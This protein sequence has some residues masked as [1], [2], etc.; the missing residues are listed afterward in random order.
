MIEIVTDC[1]QIKRLY[2]KFQEVIT[3]HFNDKINC[4]LGY[5]GG[6]SKVEVHYS[7]KLN[8][9]VSFSIKPEPENRYWC[10]FG[11]NK[12]SSGKSNSIV[13]EINFSHNSNNKRI[14]GVF[15]QENN[16][17]MVLH[18]GKIGGGKKGIGKNLLFDKYIGDFENVIEQGKETKFCYI[19]E[20]NSKYFPEQLKLFVT[21]INRIKN[22]TINPPIVAN[23]GDLT[24][25][26]YT[27][28]S[29]GISISKPKYPIKRERIHGIVV[30]LLR[31]EI[32]KISP[33]VN[34]ANDKERDLFTYNKQNTILFEV[35]TDSSK[36]S[37]YSAIGQLLL[38]S[39]PMKKVKLVTVLP[40]RLS[41]D[42]TKKINE[43]GIEILYYRWEKENSIVFD[44]LN[45]ILDL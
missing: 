18:R 1:P 5:Q 2:K 42:V 8:I 9:W 36:Q 37:L 21:E 10:G 6:S 30:D 13:V 31:K 11:I 26:Q 19:G 41:K 45:T 23:F 15:A 33:N 43:L 27:A 22:D 14:Q 25:F 40:D 20:L 16:N 44:N 17:I 12:P 35:K 34:V 38:Y 32:T 29:H 7:S 4:V 24:K 28:E 39:I 3:K